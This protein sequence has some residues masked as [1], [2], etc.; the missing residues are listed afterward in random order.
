MIP[1]SGPNKAMAGGRTRRLGPIVLAAILV[2][3]SSAHSVR[4]EVRISG[5]RD[6]V[7]IEARD[8]PV[9]EVLSALNTRF[10]LRY[11]SAGSLERRVSGNYEGSLRRLVKKLLQGC[12]FFMKT[13][14]EVVDVVVISALEC[15]PVVTPAAPTKQ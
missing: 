7:R 5:N 12:D 9:E 1:P 3:A 8:A 14:S 10:G 4:A 6:A 11:R 15:H 2:A 13:Q